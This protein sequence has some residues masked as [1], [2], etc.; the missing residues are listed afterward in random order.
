MKTSSRLSAFLIALALVALSTTVFSARVL[1]QNGDW[2]IEHADYGTRYR[3]NDVSDILRD[4]ISRGGVN[5]RVAVNNQTMGGDPAVGQDKRLRIFA[6][7]Q[8]G[9]EREFDYREGGAIDVTIFA[10]P[11]EDRDDRGDRDQDHHDHDEGDDRGRGDRDDFSI[12]F[13]FYGVQRQMANVTDLLRSMARHRGLTLDVN[14]RTLGGDPAPGADK[15]LIV[16]YRFRGQEQATAV[17]EGH[18]LDIP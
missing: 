6:R 10:V 1:A 13:G 5:G 11:R 16:V 12:L 14:N 2:R 7:N 8:L 18:R 15:V 4:L 9:E 3:S 17:G